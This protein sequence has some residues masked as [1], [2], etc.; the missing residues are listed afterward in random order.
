MENGFHIAIADLSKVRGRLYEVNRINVPGK[1]RENGFGRQLLNMI[2]M[3]AD[4]NHVT[5]RLVPLESG[6]LTSLQLAAWYQRH[7][8]QQRDSGYFYRESN[9][10]TERHNIR[11]IEV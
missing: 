5:L 4:K 7:G 11:P 3:E 1:Y 6:G 9:Q 8:F 2:C 10:L